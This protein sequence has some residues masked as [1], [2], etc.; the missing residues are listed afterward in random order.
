[1]GITQQAA[2]RAERD[3]IRKRWL[4][5]ALVVSDEVTTCR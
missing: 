2:D 4:L 5:S 1:M 3:A